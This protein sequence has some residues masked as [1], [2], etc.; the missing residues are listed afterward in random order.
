MRAGCN[1]SILKA[2]AGLEMMIAL[3]YSALKKF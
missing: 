1:V 3:L 2:V